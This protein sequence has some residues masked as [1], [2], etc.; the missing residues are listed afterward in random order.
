[1]RWN[2][3]LTRYYQLVLNSLSAVLGIVTT[4]ELNVI[5]PF[6]VGVGYECP[7]LYCQCRLTFYSCRVSVG[8]LLAVIVL[9][10]D[11]IVVALVPLVTGLV[12]VI[13]V[14]NLSQIITILG[15]QSP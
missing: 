2:N 5:L 1:M 15:I 10:V 11:G 4:A 3:L 14:L 13:L 9:A 6:L 12:H 8:Q 7:C